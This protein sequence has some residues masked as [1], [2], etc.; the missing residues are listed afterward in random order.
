MPLSTGNSG[1]PSEQSY[2]GMIPPRESDDRRAMLIHVWSQMAQQHWDIALNDLEAAGRL[3]PAGR[4]AQRTA[5]NMRALREQQPA[6]YQ[7]L[8]K[9]FPIDLQNR[10]YRPVRSKGG[11]TTIVVRTIE[12]DHLI[13]AVEDPHHAAERDVRKLADTLAQDTPLLLCGLSDGYFFDALT[14]RPREHAGGKVSA[15]FLVEPEPEL[16]LANLA[17]HDFSAKRGPIAGGW[18][19][20]FVGPDWHD[21]LVSHM[22]DQW[23]LPVPGLVLGRKDLHPQLKQALTLVKDFRKQSAGQQ[24]A[25]ALKHGVY[26]RREELVRHLRA[27]AGRAPRVLLIAPRFGETPDG[28]EAQITAGFEQLGWEV[29]PLHETAA[30]HRLT[31]LP[32]WNALGDIKPDLVFVIGERWAD[33][34]DVIDPRIPVVRW[35]LDEHS[36][37]VSTADRATLSLRDFVL[38]QASP[39]TG[40]L[41]GYPDRQVLPMPG[42]VTITGNL[43]HTSHADPDSSIGPD[44]LFIGD[45]AGDPRTMLADITQRLTNPQISQLAE[46]TGEQM[47]DDYAQGKHYATRWDIDQLARQLTPQVRGLKMSEKLYRQL[48]HILFAPFNEALYRQQALGWALD[49]ADELDLTLA[50]HGKG[51]RKLDR[52]K[53]VAHAAPSTAHRRDQLTAQAKINLHLAPGFC[54]DTRLMQ[55]LAAGGFFLV[56]R[57]PADA[58]LPEIVGF[59]ENHCTPVPGRTKRGRK[60]APTAPPETAAQARDACDK[61]HLPQLGRL[62]ARAQWINDLGDGLDPIACVRTCLRG[63][64]L[65]KHHVALPRLD[66]CEFEDNK[67]LQQRIERFLSAPDKRLDV[68][69]KQ[70]AAIEHRLSFSSGLA[71]SIARIAELV[72]SEA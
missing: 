46:L 26:T 41:K 50:I 69:K 61:K 70:R 48:A 54:L 68:V 58:L 38:A 62:L 18:V 20:W 22:Q 51:W 16:L 8:F 10:H 47:L 13:N 64:L 5:L 71:R 19:E 57:H 35:L 32:V 44:L 27:D 2:A 12:G 15:L 49:L 25:E 65:D 52:F 17:L 1:N 30:H 14:Q 24:R 40:G 43:Q 29:H 42:V 39:L 53:H 72:E 11:W 59:L 3:G 67:Q 9:L 55:G 6:V 7:Q 37:K 66:Q 31:P 45:G 56:R 60:A 34:R 28:A 4:M 36:D 33:R 23:M 21:Q 63:G